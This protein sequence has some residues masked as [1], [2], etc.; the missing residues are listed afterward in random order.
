MKLYYKRAAIIGDCHGNREFLER[1]IWQASTCDPE[2]DVVIQV[3]DFGVWP[4]KGHMHNYS[5]DLPVYFVDGNHEHH[6]WLLAHC[7]EKINELGNNVFYVNRGVTLE[8]N[9]T[10]VLFCGGAHSID[11]MYRQEGH[12]WFREENITDENVEKCLAVDPVDLIITHDAPRICKIVQ[13][14]YPLAMPNREKLD[15]IHQH[16]KP[17]NWYF[18][19]FHQ[20]WCWTD[21]DSGTRFFCCGADCNSEI[22]HNGGMPTGK[23]Y[24]QYAVYDFEEKREISTDGI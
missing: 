19:H 9:N 2:I 16:H 17:A 8:I 22:L 11:W 14:D 6:P 4:F 5:Y 3:G 10:S 21:P 23:R 1:A 13:E 24:A 18:G 20:N 7:P 12:S 15:V